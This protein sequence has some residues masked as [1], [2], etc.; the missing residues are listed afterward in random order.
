MAPHLRLVKGQ[1]NADEKS[2]GPGARA[3]TPRQQLLVKTYL[4][5]VEK[6]AASVAR[7]HGNQVSPAELLG[8]GA[9]ALHEAA[10]TYEE[11]KHPDFEH[12]ARHHVRGR[13]L[14]A[15][16]A[17]RFSARAR[18]ERA[19]ERGF[20]R[21]ATHQILEVDTVMESEERILEEAER[22]GDDALAAA[23]LAGM[24]EQQN[25]DPEALFIAR[26]EQERA[27]GALKKGIEALAA[28]ER[29]V[30]RL[31][32]EQSMTLDEVAREL[33]KGLRTVQ[34]HHVCALRKL[35]MCLVNEDIERTALERRP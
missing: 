25:H 32:Y 24:L 11:E 29:R 2:E 27:L 17:E 18:V 13:M 22:G 19:M 6:N 5:M 21:F 4:P 3:L 23:V 10:A 35:R 28:H 14:D 26:E 7:R 31:V 33:S 15:I 8:P 34:R 30:I 9:V 12:Y 1:P 20:E 16:R